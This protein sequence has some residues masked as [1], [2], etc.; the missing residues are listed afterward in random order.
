MASCCFQTCWVFLNGFIGGVRLIWQH[1]E[2]W[3]SPLIQRKIIGILWMVP[4]YA[5]TSWL[6]LRFKDAA[7]YLDMFRDCYE[8]YVIYLF[9]ALMIAYLGNGS[10]HKVH[11]ILNDMAEPLSHPFPMNLVWAPIQMDATF[12]RRCKFGVMQF[13]A[14][15]PIMTVLASLMESQNMY[16]KGQFRIDRG[17]AYVSFIQNASITWA[18]Y[19]LVLFYLALK[20]QLKPYD[21]VPKFLAIK[22]V[23]FLSFWQGVL[24][25]ALAQFGVIDQIGNWTVENVSTGVQNWLICFEMA[26]CAFAHIY[27]FPYQPFVSKTARIDPS[28]SNLRTTLLNDNLAFHDAINDFN[29]VAPGRVLLPS[30]FTPGNARITHYSNLDRGEGDGTEKTHAENGNGIHRQRWLARDAELYTTAFN[31]P[32]SLASVQSNVDG[33][34]ANGDESRGGANAY[35]KMGWTM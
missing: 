22:A 6:S 25:A 29:Q 4:I 30:S 28:S 10:E 12:L 17:Y 14:I 8:A 18:F 34:N 19:D 3:T 21:P 11:D 32:I 24:L 1:K 7:V 31:T 9:L 20:K 26:L 2:N 15:K 27:A 16:D 5:I 35:E 23:L 13:V 33:D